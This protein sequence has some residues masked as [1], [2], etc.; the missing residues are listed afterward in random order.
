MF[1]IENTLVSLDL[2]EYYF[3]CDLPNCKGNC[4][5]DGD[6]GAPLEKDE[7]EI[8][9]KILPAVWDDLSPKARQVI[10]KQGVGYIDISGETVTSI[11]NGKD[12]VF[13]YYDEDGI[14]RCAIEKAYR[15]KRIDF[16][17][18][19]SCHLYPVRVTQYKDYQAVNYHRWKVCRPGEILGEH[20][21]IPVY[22][23]LREPLIRKF[24]EKWY[25]LL[26]ICAREYRT[27]ND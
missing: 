14:C 1:E 9:R 26:D 15:E 18:P 22:R 27:F 24:G 21:K 11:V 20:A 25:E 3:Q 4:C 10:E 12:C 6:A 2:I 7:F 23:F 17:K 8:L 13:T 16:Q 5:V 19:V